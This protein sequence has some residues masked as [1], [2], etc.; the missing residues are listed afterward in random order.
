MPA[1]R[2]RTRRPA[3]PVLS[4]PAP[5]ST[6]QPLLQPCRAVSI[7]ERNER[8][9]YEVVHGDDGDRA[10]DHGL[11]RRLPP[12]TSPP[13][14]P[15][16]DMTGDRDDDEAQDERLNQTHPDVLHIERLLDGRPVKA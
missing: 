8:L 7:N 10:D 13:L 5:T 6:C 12:T 9:R 16:A 1:T 2:A 14:R 15:K 4:R 11:C 3:P